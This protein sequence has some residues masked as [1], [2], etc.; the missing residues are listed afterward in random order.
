M[1]RSFSSAHRNETE[2][3]PLPRYY[4]SHRLVRGTAPRDPSGWQLPAPE[5]EQKVAELTKQHMNGP[6]FRAEIISDASTDETAEL[7]EKLNSLGSKRSRGADD[8]RN[9]HLSLIERID[10]APGEIRI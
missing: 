4:V 9:A 8:S 10:I 2:F 1:C 3:L 6:E 5:L 7:G